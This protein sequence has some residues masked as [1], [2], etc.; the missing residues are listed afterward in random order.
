MAS[1]QYPGSAPVFVQQHSHYR[2][3]HTNRITCHAVQQITANLTYWV[4]AYTRVDAISF[5]EGFDGLREAF[6]RSQSFSCPM[7]TQT[8]ATTN[9][10]STTNANS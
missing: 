1:F 10:Q 4:L 6:C 5:S 7:M 9:Q 3:M 2:V 8:I